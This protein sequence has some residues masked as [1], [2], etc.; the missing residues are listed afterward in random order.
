[1]SKYEIIAI[2]HTEKVESEQRN[3]VIAQ[4]QSWLRNQH[5]LNTS[6]TFIHLQIW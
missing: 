4:K 6:S 2:F 5:F 3:L 1:M